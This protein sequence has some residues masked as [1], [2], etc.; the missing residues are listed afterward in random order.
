MADVLTFLVVDQ[1]GSTEQIQRL[2]DRKAAVIREELLEM[3]GSA[4][5]SWGGSVYHYTGDGLMA[6]FESADHAIWAAAQMQHASTAFSAAQSPG[7]EIVLRIGIHSGLPVITAAGHFIGID[8]HI[9]ARLC[10]VAAPASIVMSAPTRELSSW[11]A[12]AES[13]G[14]LALKGIPDPP[15]LFA[16]DWVS[17]PRPSAPYAGSTAPVLP[18][19]GGRSPELGAELTDVPPSPLVARATVRS[20]TF[21]GRSEEHEILNATWSRVLD[22]QAQLV[23]IAADAGFGKSSLAA[24]FA[25]SEPA[26]AGIVLAGRCDE[27]AS[28][29]FEPF[30]QCL[31]HLVEHI[32]VSL[33]S[34]NASVHGELLS[35]LVP[36]VGTRLGVEFAASEIDENGADRLFAAV[37]DLLGRVSQLRPIL[38]LIEDIHWANEPTVRLLRHISRAAE[39]SKLMI[40]TT[41]RQSDV[42][43]DVSPMVNDMLRE[44]D[45]VRIDLRPFTTDDVEELLG[46]MIDHVPQQA[47]TALAWK[48]AN[49]TGGVPFFV[50]EVIRH[51]R[52]TYSVGQLPDLAR[53]E[54]LPLPD[55]IIEVVQRRVDHLGAETRSILQLAAMIGTEFDL[56]VLAAIA[57][58]SDD[59]LVDAIDA[60]ESANVVTVGTGTGDEVYRFSHDLFR[61]ALAE[62]F[63]SARRRR[64]HARIAHE[65]DVQLGLSEQTAP[66]L[67]RHLVAAGRGD[68]LELALDAADIAARSATSAFAFADTVRYQITALQ[69]AESWGG[70]DREL[71]AA[72]EIALAQALNL[73]GQFTD[74]NDHFWAGADHARASGRSDLLSAAAVGYG[75]ELPTTPPPDTRAI[76]LLQEMLGLVDV[77]PELRAR[78]TARLAEWQHTTTSFD[79]RRQLCDQAVTLAGALD[80][81]ETLARVQVSRARALHGPGSCDDNRRLGHEIRQV[82]EATANDVLRF[83]ASSIICT[84]ALELGD[85]D[86][87]LEENENARQFGRRLQHV[88]YARNALMWDAML[89]NARGDW[90][91]ADRELAKLSRLLRASQHLQAGQIQGAISIPP[92]W[93]AGSAGMIHDLVSTMSPH[94]FIGMAA[95]YAAEAGRLDVAQRHLDDF[96]PVEQIAERLNYN[97]WHLCFTLSTAASELDDRKTADALHRV[98]SPFAD[99][100]A[101]MGTVA[102]LGAGQHHLGV[103]AATL[104]N[105]DE[106]DELFTTAIERHRAVGAEPWVALSQIERARVL[107]RLGGVDHLEESA[108]LAAEA[109]AAA[110][111][112]RLVAVRRRADLLVTAAQH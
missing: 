11:A 84:S 77:D 25:A 51:L 29:S 83:H 93:F 95:G 100:F 12:N 72:R 71:L 48:I 75:G 37:V 80:R 30:I 3:T 36:E 24:G 103:V 65:I 6:S 22:G 85:V 90:D 97:F 106:A 94:D 4:V 27:F 1:V 86:D 14:R 78:G 2:G 107:E 9:A 64:L 88:A 39:L 89:A 70:S 69:I 56:R 99:H 20:G 82:A 109:T 40:V 49:D 18:P 55:G 19:V 50:R 45:A 43:S 73:G 108:A 28:T 58:V 44:A 63:G 81:P 102:F 5:A 61:V 60:A 101:L 38:M 68:A 23:S 112:L 76:A 79:H 111:S 53:S 91:H 35:V 96:G 21:V 15:E 13:L 54:L 74:A 92:L 59:D 105:L 31:R 66:A 104:G 33:L 67:L 16:I 34:E 41:M 7:D 57:E 46:S 52:E 47:M 98:I 10:S 8:C 17:P 62:T 32:P 42:R 110:A 87:A 26:S